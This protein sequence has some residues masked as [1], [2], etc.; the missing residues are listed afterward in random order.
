MPLYLNTV[1]LHEGH[2]S[3]LVCGLQQE[4]QNRRF[5]YRN[6]VRADRVY[7]L[8]KHG[9]DDCAKRMAD[10]SGRGMH[11]VLPD[12]LRVHLVYLNAV[13]VMMNKV[14]CADWIASVVYQF[15]FVC[16]MYTP[17]NHHVIQS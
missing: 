8:R 11:A 6:G 1:H 14:T 5:C 12:A 2:V 3:G 17:G 15:V 10:G 9:R 13:S 4:I 16:A 7:R